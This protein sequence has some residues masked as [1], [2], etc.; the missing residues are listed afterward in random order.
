MDPSSA[1]RSLSNFVCGEA[2]IIVKSVM[3]E[4]LAAVALALLPSMGGGEPPT[5]P[6]PGPAAAPTTLI[7]VRHAEK[8]TEGSDPD[9]SPAG[10]ARARELA[11]MLADVE[12][13]A[14]YATQYRRTQET[15]RPVAQGAGLAVIVDPADARDLDRYARTFVR[16]VLERHAGGTIVVVGHSN[17]VPAFIRAMGAARLPTIDER[18]YD[19]L[20]VVTVS[21][22]G[23]ARLLPL[24]Y[25]K[26][27]REATAG[28]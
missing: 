5:E 1:S 7:L 21:G 26:P 28:D 4:A 13:A 24:R 2:A 8:E 23:D 16:R 9:L 11:R 25:G 18:I 12:I 27:S 14:V 10:R 6:S 17:T 22:N 3:V 19:H 20:F 15:A